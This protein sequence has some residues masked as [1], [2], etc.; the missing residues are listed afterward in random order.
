MKRYKEHGFTLIEVMI[1]LGIATVVILTM[2]IV[3][4]GAGTKQ[5]EAMALAQIGVFNRMILGTLGNDLAWRTTIQ[6]GSAGGKNPMGQMDCL[7]SVNTP[8]T[9]GATPGGL[10]I[11]NQPFT[12]Y[13]AT[14]QIV[15]DAINPTQGLTLQGTVCNNYSTPPA[16]GNDDCPFRYDLT[17]SANCKIGNCTNPQVEI[18]GIFHYNPS[19]K[20]KNRIDVDTRRFDIS[21]Y[22]V[23]PPACATGFAAYLIPGTQTFLVPDYK[24]VLVVEAWG[25]GGG[26]AGI[27]PVVG[28]AGGDSSFNGNVVAHG[29]AG[30]NASTPPFWL[31]GIPIGLAL[32]GTASGGDIN[33]TGGSTTN[34]GG[35]AAPMSGM[36]TILPPSACTLV[37]K[38]GAGGGSPSFP[39]GNGF[40]GQHMGGGGGGPANVM[41]IRFSPIGWWGFTALGGGGGGYVSKAFPP[42]MWPVN[43]TIQ[44]IVGAGG[45]GGAGL[46]STFAIGPYFGGNG[47]NGAVLI[48]WE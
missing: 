8:C 6:Q 2:T 23:A 25:A 36:Q 47:A 3:L 48:Q 43:K 41:I 33:I 13:D 35:G 26:A 19:T 37:I 16:S 28:T 4:S 44:V 40:P 29:G 31:N 34:Q 14:G 7:T 20:A 9:A 46:P 12:L 32:G 21:R 45:T 39:G 22:F 11:T 38:G 30:G 27:G 1:T 18:N 42:G 5:N 10:P 17:W 15:Y 24:R